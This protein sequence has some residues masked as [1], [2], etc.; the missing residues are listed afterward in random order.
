MILECGNVW[1]QSGLESIEK[2]K[3]TIKGWYTCDER[4]MLVVGLRGTEETEFFGVH[5]AG[6]P[7]LQLLINNIY[8]CHIYQLNSSS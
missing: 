6:M 5:I 4:R 7:C 3:S 1:D 2:A 8:N